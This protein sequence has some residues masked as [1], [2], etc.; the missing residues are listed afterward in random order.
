VNNISNDLIV[1][2]EYI[3]KSFSSKHS[4]SHVIK[5]V[6]YSINRGDFIAI[7]GES[8]SGK[9][10]LLSIIGLLEFYDSGEYKLCGQDVSTLDEWQLNR[11]RN[12]N[13]GW[14]FQNFNLISDMTVAENILLPLRYSDNKDAQ[15][16][17]E[18]LLN[19]VLDSVDLKDK[20]NSYPN[21]L[22][23]GQQQRVAI[24]RALI[25]DPDL[26]LADE[27][28]GNLDSQT[29]DMIFELLVKLNVEGKTIV[30][31]THSPRLAE[32]AGN[33]LILKDGQ[34]ENE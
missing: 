20:K 29:A 9:S 6:C 34:I 13:I 11:L 31:V 21:E 19:N 3:N 17:F 12:N 10:T 2:M 33:R 7:S 16:N 14:I 24:A 26:I 28:T 15:I 22:S 4:I 8:G 27:P 23:G 25:T 32:L 30:M 18:I 5:D 1:K